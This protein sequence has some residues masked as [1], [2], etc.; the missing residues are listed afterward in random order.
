MDR[1]DSRRE[2][3]WVLGEAVDDGP[4]NGCGME[5]KIDDV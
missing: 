5:V 4:V 2:L 1:R 3:F